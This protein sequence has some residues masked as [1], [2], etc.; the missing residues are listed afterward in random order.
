MDNDK[1]VEKKEVAY[2]II[3]KDKEAKYNKTYSG[4]CCQSEIA[5]FVSC[6]KR[7]KKTEKHNGC[8]CTIQ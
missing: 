4:R 8:G 3:V 7:E 1:T 5:D 2:T 6:T